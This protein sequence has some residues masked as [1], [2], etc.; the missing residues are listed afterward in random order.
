MNNDMLPSTL[1]H[2]SRVTGITKLSIREPK[3]PAFGPGIYLTAD[4]VVA[5]LYA[6]DR[7]GSIYEVGIK[8]NHRLTVNLDAS[9]HHQ[10]TEVK[11]AIMRVHRQLLPPP[12]HGCQF[13]T[14][15]AA[16][17]LMSMQ[18]MHRHNPNQPHLL[19]YLY[20]YGVSRAATNR[21]LR[22]EGIWLIYGH[23]RPI[24]GG[25]G[26]ADRGIQYAIINENHVE[27]LSEHSP[28]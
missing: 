9:L 21:L 2:G 7:N 5:D 16:S 6:Y 24:H 3:N 14:K 22:Q 12:S 13:D 19:E 26:R 10:H 28:S 4:E 15:S 27:I 8:G 1:Y 23:L 18:V 11:I 20:P 17:N 25:S